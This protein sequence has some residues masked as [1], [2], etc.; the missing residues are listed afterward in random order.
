MRY[1]KLNKRLRSLY[2]NHNYEAFD[3]L[4][5]PYQELAEL[6]TKLGFNEH[7][8]VYRG[9]IFRA[10]PYEESWYDSKE[11]DAYRKEFPHVKDLPA[12]QKEFTTEGRVFPINQLF[13]TTT[14]RKFAESMAGF[15]NPVKN[16]T[17]FL[18]T[19]PIL[20]KNINQINMLKL[21][22]Y[23]NKKYSL[24]SLGISKD[25]TDN[26]LAQIKAIDEIL[27][28]PDRKMV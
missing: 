11:L 2:N 26:F 27:L 20:K 25:I 24:D 18:F 9:I 17:K 1:K 5:K 14:S 12:I 22:K 15:K 23:F 8:T 21:Y 10:K 16:M 28:V 4:V 3:K 6:N 13:A 19:I 7:Q